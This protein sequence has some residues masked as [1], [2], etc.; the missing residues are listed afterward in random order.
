VRVFN[1]QTAMASETIAVA[2]APQTD[3]DGDTMPDGYESAH[4]CLSAAAADGTADPDVDSASSAAEYQAGT[5]PCTADTDG[6]N[7]LDGRE[8]R[9]SHVKGG[10]RDPADPFDFMDVPTPALRSEA[11]GGARN[12]FVN[13]GDLLAILA[14]VGTSVGGTANGLGISYDADVDGNG[15]SDGA[16]YDRS[17]PPDISRPWA[18]GPPTGQVAINDVLVALNQVGDDCSQA[19]VSP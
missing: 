10:E 14:Y 16:Q 12:G 3:T 19:V 4:E 9:I 7:C 5:L 2:V 13:I 18:S 15:V 8:L 17:A 6:D 11:P 1:E